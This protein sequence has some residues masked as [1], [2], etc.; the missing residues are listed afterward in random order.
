MATTQSNA[1]KVT[2]S[3]RVAHSIAE[4]CA[5]T[6]LGRDGVYAAIRS[7][8]LVA[9]KFGRRRVVL[10]DDLRGFLNALPRLGAAS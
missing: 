4:V 7:G 8:D 5:A 6:G 1:T 9:R 2:H 10:D 3:G